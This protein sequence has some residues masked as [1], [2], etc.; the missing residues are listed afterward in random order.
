MY[1]LLANLDGLLLAS[2]SDLTF[3]P[4]IGDV[5]L[6]PKESYMRGPKREGRLLARLRKEH[7]VIVSCGNLAKI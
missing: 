4:L 3:S 1:V 5:V 7:L 6:G 2:I